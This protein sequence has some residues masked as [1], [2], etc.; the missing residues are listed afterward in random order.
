MP[1][2]DNELWQEVLDLL[3]RALNEYGIA[4]ALMDVREEVVVQARATLQ[5]MESAGLV[6]HESEFV[7]KVVPDG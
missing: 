4:L 6:K 3:P 7:W 2:T 1:T 5:E